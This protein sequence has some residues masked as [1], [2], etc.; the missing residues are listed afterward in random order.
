MK[1]RIYRT[2]LFLLFSI[3]LTNASAQSFA[4]GISPKI[5]FNIDWQLNGTISN[6]FADG[7]SGWGAA[8]ESGYYLTPSIGVGAFM[9]FHTNNEYIPRSVFNVDGQ[10]IST[11]QQHSLFQLP[12]G[13]SARYRFSQGMLTPYVGVKAGAEYAESD[14]YMNEVCVYNNAWGFYMSPEVGVEIRPFG[15]NR[16]GF[17]LSAYYSYS[18]NDNSLMWYDVNGLNNYGFRIGIAF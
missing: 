4:D 18:T 8:F 1:T 12:F 5:Y 16:I 3:T 2:L 14:S 17:H 7:I 15:T 13:V 9:G 6:D 10:A 11:D